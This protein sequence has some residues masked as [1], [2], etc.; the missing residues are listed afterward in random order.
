LSN[1]QNE[2]ALEQY[3]AKKYRT[4]DGYTSD[5]VI[6]T[7]FDS[8]LYL[9]LIQR[10]LTTN[11]GT[12]NIEGGKWA[13]P[14]G[15]IDPDETA[16]DSALR[17]LK[18]ETGI[19]NIH[20]KHF[21]TYEKE[22]RDPRGWMITNA[23]YAILPSHYLD[24]RTAGDDA[25]DVKLFPIDELENMEIAF[26]HRQI[27]EDALSE[28]RKDML[29]TTLAKEFLREE[30]TLSELSDVILTVVDDPVVSS[31][32][33]FFRKAPTLPFLELVVDKEG[34][35]ITT[36]RGAKKPTKLYRFRD[37]EI[38]KSIYK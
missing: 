27:I 16:Y 31:K 23:H 36:Q 28:V 24:S 18:E 4:P 22:G 12:A 30:F 6:F 21:A 14:G 9:L 11:E 8:T 10:S 20:V 26:D 7:I 1:T 34:N 15:F 25:M 3:D 37:D 17:E 32:P 38:I 29:Q 33:F 19:E 5:N 13:L 35:A 2:K